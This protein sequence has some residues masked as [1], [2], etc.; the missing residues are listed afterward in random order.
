MV[1]ILGQRL[2][3]QRQ[4]R[5][6]SQRQLAT[7]AQVSHTILSKLE[8]GDRDNIMSDV[9]RSL[10]RALGCSADYLIDLYGEDE[11]ATVRS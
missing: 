1:S 6:L 7:R 3:Q 9:L 8:S 11:R 2:K 10:A 4:A 5:G